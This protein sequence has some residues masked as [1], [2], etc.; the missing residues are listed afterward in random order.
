MMSAS[1]GPIG[2]DVLYD[3][4]TLLYGSPMLSMM[5]P[6]SRGGIVSRS[7]SST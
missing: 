5:P 1:P 6:S 4:L 7:A 3:R 2:A